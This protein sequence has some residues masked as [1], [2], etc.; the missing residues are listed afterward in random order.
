MSQAGQ[1]EAI[2]AYVDEHAEAMLDQLKTLVR[3]PSI[4]AQDVGVKECADLLA[5]MILSRG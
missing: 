2:G 5:G 1:L 4:S 3:Q